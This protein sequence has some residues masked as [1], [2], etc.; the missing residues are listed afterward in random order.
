M[1]ITTMDMLVAALNASKRYSIYK[2]SMT[3]KAAGEFQS[4]M[5]AAGSPGAGSTPATG[6]GAI[7]TNATAGSIPIVNPS[8]SNKEYLARLGFAGSVAGS[9]ILYDR[10][11]HNSGLSGTSTSAQTFTQP[12]LTRYTDGLGVEAFVE[13]YTAL[14]STAS[15]F[16]IS[17]TNSDGTAGR[18]GTYTKPATAPVAGQMYPIS[19]AAGDK[20]IRSIQSVQLSA[21]TGTTGNFGLVLVRR[22]A[23][24][25]IPVVNASN[26][27]DSFS[28]GMPE[29]VSNSALFL[30]AMCSAATTGNIIGSLETIEG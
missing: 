24:I 9:I 3:S 27:R 15:T 17:Y 30:M 12:V 13:I 22:F 26:D 14:G 18:S 6:A 4:L 29:I 11:W 19:L 20:G 5:L 1:A 25:G 8:G 2:A 10:L 28:L 23:E 21:S 16:T 7:P